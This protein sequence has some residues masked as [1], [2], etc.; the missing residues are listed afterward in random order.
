MTSQRR[1]A[2]DMETRL[3]GD[4]EHG[5]VETRLHGVHGL[6]ITAM[7][8]GNT[9]RRLAVSNHP[10]RVTAAMSLGSTGRRAAIAGATIVQLPAVICCLPDW[11]A[12]DRVLPGGRG[13]MRL[14]LMLFKD[15][16]FRSR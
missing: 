8:L 4:V 5:H 6:H 12:S 14:G 3:H 9:G 15:K 1:G 11:M 2:G 16:I 7:N 10:Q 13:R